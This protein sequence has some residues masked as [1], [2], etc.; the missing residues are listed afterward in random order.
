MTCVCACHLLRT[1]PEDEFT[2]VLSQLVSIHH[3][4]LSVV[5]E[6]VRLVLNNGADPNDLI[7]DCDSKARESASPGLRTITALHD[8][9]VWAHCKRGN[10][11][12]NCYPMVRLLM[13]AHGD[14][15]RPAPSSGRTAL[16]YARM[17]DDYEL[18]KLLEP[19]RVHPE[20]LSPSSSS[21]KPVRRST[22]VR[23]R[24]RLAGVDEQRLKA[25]PDPLPASASNE[26]VKQHK[27]LTRKIQKANLQIVSRAEA[28]MAR[29]RE[30][31]GSYL[32]ELKYDDPDD[33]SSAISDN[34]SDIEGLSNEGSGSESSG[35]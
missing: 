21:K 22:P 9:C 15:N 3:S 23:E 2:C 20:E 7:R 13:E 35:D 26:E 4:E 24:A 5:K 19:E 6:L 28:S 18:M 31:L 12:W 10:P 33:S 14:P 30:R 29:R 17:K 34:V 32:S 16:Q 11:Y 8:A 27:Q 1:D 25:L